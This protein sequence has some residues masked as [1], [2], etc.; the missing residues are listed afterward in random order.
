MKL[1]NAE[2]EGQLKEV[3]NEMK[4]PIELVH[5]TKAGAYTSEETKQYMEEIAALSEQI[6]LRVVDFDASPELV[7]QYGIEMVPST[8]FLNDKGI[9][10]GVKFN[11]IPAGHEI[12]SF[13]SAILEVSGAGEEAP[14]EL[15]QYLEG[16]KQPVNIKVFITLGCP[17]CPGAVQKAHKLAL[18][19]PMITGEM[20]EAETFGELSTKFNVSSVPHI[21]IN[22]AY[23][24][25]GNQ[26]LEAFLQEIQKT[27]Q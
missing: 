25:V 11:G 1:F 2:L 21:V 10:E 23:S 4:A 12:N 26:P 5:F 3:F 14:D 18:L 20:V 24:F 13:V 19:S 15:K 22:D 9:Y 7:S 8:I 27:Q 6:T 16:L 17:H